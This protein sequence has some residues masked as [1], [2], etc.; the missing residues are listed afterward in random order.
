MATNVQRF[1]GTMLVLTGLLGFGVAGMSDEVFKMSQGWLVAAIIIWI[2][3]NGVL[4]A[5]IR[6]TEKVIAAGG[7][8]VA[9]EKKL[10]MGGGTISLLLLLQ[11]YLMVFKPG[12]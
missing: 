3:M 12:L 9:V 11:L 6:P 4:H 7:S 8:T 10:A 2:A 1:Y 5:V